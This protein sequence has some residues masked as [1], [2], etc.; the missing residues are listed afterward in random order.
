MPPKFKELGSFTISYTIGILAIGKAL[1]D[2]EAS[3]NLMPLSMMRKMGDLKLKP[4]RIT[5]QLVYQSIECPYGVI[6]DV[7]VKVDIFP[8]LVD[9]FILEVEED[10]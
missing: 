2:L 6:E 10:V 4:T 9:I 5:L 7:L 8:F 1:I 3:I